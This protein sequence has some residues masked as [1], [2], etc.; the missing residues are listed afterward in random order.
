[1]AKRFL[2]L[3]GLLMLGFFVAGC[4]EGDESASVV[5][6]NPE[7]FAPTGSISGVVLDLCSGDTIEGATVWVAY[8]GKQHKVVTGKGGVFSF[9][10]VPANGNALFEDWED[11]YIV[12]CDL[13]T[14]TGDPYSGARYVERV[15]VGYASLLDGT[16][17]GLDEE[18]TEGGSGAS[19]PVDKLAATVAFEVATATNS[20]AGMVIDKTFGT[21]PLASATV[22][23]FDDDGNLIANTTTGADGSFNL[24]GVPASDDY[25]SIMVTKSG[26]TYYDLYSSTECD[27]DECAKMELNCKVGCSSIPLNAGLFFVEQSVLKDD[28]M[29]FVANIDAQIG[30]FAA[31]GLFDWDE[32][33]KDNAGDDLAAVVTSFGITFSEPMLAGHSSI[34]DGVGLDADFIVVV[35]TAGETTTLYPSDGYTLY[36]IDYTLA[37]NAAKT[38]LT[39]VPAI[40]FDDEAIIDAA[41]D[42]GID[43]GGAWAFD[44]ESPTIT[45]A[46]AWYEITFGNGSYPTLSLADANGCP[47][48][49]EDYDADSDGDND[50]FLSNLAGIQEFILGG[51]NDFD[52]LVGNEDLVGWFD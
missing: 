31:A 26:Y 29:P 50:L 28:I 17:M 39:L 14:V 18:V 15:Y 32:L 47:W 37:W 9:D 35:S 33:T 20:V 11:G 8:S 19:T 2:V 45:P 21:D 27:G 46:A 34:Y 38:V 7:V 23:L 22:A 6:P 48:F 3:V 44:L 24:T 16:N 30:T 40:T 42:E 4:S 10:K 51:S 25:Y 49:Y 43:D 13:G 5:N 52:L 12:T 41:Q 36:D 1:M